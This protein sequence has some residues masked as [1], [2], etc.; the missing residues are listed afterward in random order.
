MKITPYCVACLVQRQEERIRKYLD[1]NLKLKYMKEVLTFIGNEKE[2]VTAPYLIGE[3]DEIHKKYFGDT[4]SYL[5]LKQEYN[6]LMLSKEDELQYIIKHSPD[7]LLTALKLAR[8]GNYIDFGA[9]KEI[10]ND[11]LRELLNRV[12]NETIDVSEY[13]YFC[14]EL[15]KGRN[16]VYITDNC[17]EIVLDKLFILTMKEYYP[18]L[19][20][21]IIVRGTHVLN[22]AT[23][24][25]AKEVGLTEIALVL[26]NGT[27]I[28]GT[29]LT[30]INKESKQAIDEADV[31]ISKGQANFETLYGSGLNIY[32]MFLCK[33]DLFVKRFGMELYQGIFAKEKNIKL[34]Y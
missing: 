3:I 1:E 31:I 17:G 8:V 21:S 10:S 6:Q 12:E 15:F 32:Y 25:D 24:E 20:I 2:E 19:N 9:M 13:K 30:E 16:L 22:D 34:L 27:K 23:Y 33:C 11:K 5:D 18:N 4:D 29:V 28:P 14:D 7:P 26:G